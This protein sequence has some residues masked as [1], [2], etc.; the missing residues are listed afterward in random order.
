MGLGPNWYQIGNRTCYIPKV[1][2]IYVEKD[3][4]GNRFKRFHLLHVNVYLTDQN[5]LFI[6]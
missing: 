1:R 3:I 2:K 6:L 5:M 4:Y